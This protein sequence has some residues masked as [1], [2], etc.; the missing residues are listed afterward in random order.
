[1]TDIEDYQLQKLTAAMLIDCNANQ[2]IH[3]QDAFEEIINNMVNMLNASGIT[4]ELPDIENAVINSI[5]VGL[6]ISIDKK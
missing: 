6:K 5:A 1:M 2:F 4:Y 3:I